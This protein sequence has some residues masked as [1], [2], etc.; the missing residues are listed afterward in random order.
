MSDI[1]WNTSKKDTLLIF[2]IASRA[3]KILGG[4]ASD[5]AMD[6]TA[7]HMNGNPLRLDEL[8][9]ADDFNFFHDVCGINKHIDRDNGKLIHGFMPRYSK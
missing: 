6:I 8:L 3:Q 2:Q 1:N 9:L 5:I 7:C 4:D